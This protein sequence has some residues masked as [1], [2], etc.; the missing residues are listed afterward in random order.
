MVIDLC[1]SGKIDQAMWLI[2]DSNRFDE[3]SMKFLCERIEAK[4]RG[5]NMTQWNRNMDAAPKDGTFVLVYGSIQQ[6]PHL[7]VTITG[8]VVHAVANYE[9]AD[10]SWCVVGGDWLGP[11]IEPIAW[12]PLPEAPGVQNG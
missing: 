7:S 12:M 5:D 2:H 10:E 9:L 3:T 11:F 1:N 6:H 4:M 8:P